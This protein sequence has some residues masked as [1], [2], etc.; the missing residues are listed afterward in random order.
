[1]NWFG[2]AGGRRMRANDARHAPP[3]HRIAEVMQEE[4][5]SLRTAA[6][7][8]N[9]SQA[10]VSAELNGTTDLTLSAL[11]RWQTLLNV[12]VADLLREPDQTLSPHVK[13]RTGLMKA[14]RTVRSIQEHMESEPIQILAKQLARQLTELMPE[15]T[16]TS[17]WPVVGQR[18]TLDELGVI[19]QRQYS[20]ELF[21]HPSRE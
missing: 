1:M 14:M 11:H 8:F 19:A 13:F 10:E 15:L 6:R 20:D 16:H 18:R 12:P 9:M 21:N 4:D 7:R 5:V 3:L 17:G 2:L